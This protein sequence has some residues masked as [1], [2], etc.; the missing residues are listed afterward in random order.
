[1]YR[2][3]HWPPMQALALPTGAAQ[4][5]AAWAPAAVAQE[6]LARQQV[7][8]AA[9]Q[10]AQAARLRELQRVG[11]MERRLVA[12]LLRPP[13]QLLRTRRPR[14]TRRPVHPSA[15]ACEGYQRSFDAFILLRG[16]QA[17]RVECCRQSEDELEKSDGQDV[18]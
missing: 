12:W 15:P 6:A 11:L 4:E 8:Q 10:R 5:G 16:Q 13:G 2:A 7:A 17:E 14:R 1:M 18:S 3:S 9:R